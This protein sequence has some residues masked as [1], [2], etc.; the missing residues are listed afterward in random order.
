MTR[1]TFF[2]LWLLGYSPP[3]GGIGI[4]LFISCATICTIGNRKLRL[5]KKLSIPHFKPSKEL[6]DLVNANGQLA[7]LPPEAAGPAA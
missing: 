7:A 2:T 4:I 6:K 1:R 5:R 3:K